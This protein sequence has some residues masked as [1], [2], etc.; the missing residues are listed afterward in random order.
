MFLTLGFI[1]NPPTLHRGGEYSGERS[2]PWTLAL[3]ICLGHCSLL[4]HFFTD[5]TFLYSLGHFRK[6]TVTDS[7]CLGH[8]SGT[9]SVLSDIFLLRQ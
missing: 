2:L 7:P 3:D 4:G 8:F 5:V 9:F 1:R 6:E